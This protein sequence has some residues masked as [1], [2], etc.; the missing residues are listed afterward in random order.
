MQDN[1]EPLDIS[2][3]GFAAFERSLDLPAGFIDGL[4]KEDDWSF[5]IKA[6]RH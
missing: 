1:A 4:K 2:V 5:G 3:N 6:P